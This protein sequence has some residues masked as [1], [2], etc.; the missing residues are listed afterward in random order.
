MDTKLNK[1]SIRIGVDLIDR[2]HFK[3]LS[4][5]NSMMISIPAL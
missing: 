1:A 2:Q 3:Y 5:V 4:I